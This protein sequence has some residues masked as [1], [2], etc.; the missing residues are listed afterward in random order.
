MQT[1]RQKDNLDSIE[2][3]MADIGDLPEEMQKDIQQ[4]S[5]KASK[6]KEVEQIAEQMADF[7]DMLGGF[8]DS[9]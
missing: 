9:D 1:N 4:Q 8:E 3:Q 2:D 6:P 7:A 5:D